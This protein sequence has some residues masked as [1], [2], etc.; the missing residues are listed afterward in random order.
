MKCES[1]P[2]TE[3][4]AACQVESGLSYTVPSVNARYF[5]LFSSQFSPTSHGRARSY[6]IQISIILGKGTFA[7]AVYFVITV[8]RTL[9]SHNCSLQ[10][11]IKEYACL[12]CSTHMFRGH[13]CAMLHIWWPYGDTGNRTMKKLCR[14]DGKQSVTCCGCQFSRPKCPLGF[15]LWVA[16]TLDSL[17]SEEQVTYNLEE[18]KSRK[19]PR[20]LLK[21]G[22]IVEMMTHSIQV[23]QHNHNSRMGR[24][25]SIQCSEWFI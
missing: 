7:D 13:T 14:P 25:S 20:L 23:D 10:I 15:Y 17:G 16:A 22:Q 24:T 6:W 2:I 19:R 3:W 5:C 18:Q 11:D 9:K 8:H 21:L 12:H 4:C 1:H